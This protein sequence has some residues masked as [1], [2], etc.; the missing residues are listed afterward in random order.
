[1]FYGCIWRA[2]ELVSSSVHLSSCMEMPWEEATE[3]RRWTTWK[4]PQG[5]TESPLWSLSFTWDTWF[6]FVALLQ[7]KTN[8]RVE[9]HVSF[10][11]WEWASCA[12]PQEHISSCL[13]TAAL[14]ISSY[15]HK[16]PLLAGSFA[17]TAVGQ[18][19]YQ[20]PLKI[21]KIW[22][23][24]EQWP[25]NELCTLGFGQCTGGEHT[26]ACSRRKGMKK[27]NVD[28]EEDCGYKVEHF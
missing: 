10:W 16:Y 3:M 4:R 24:W 5:P 15:I 12:P 9:H 21:S 14:K 8:W 18:C 11:S 17:A 13:D 6:L 27:K 28:G 25:E 26:S 19:K 7:E 23:Y 20:E 1:M 22:L 2:G